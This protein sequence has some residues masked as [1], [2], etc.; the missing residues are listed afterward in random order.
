MHGAKLTT[1]STVRRHTQLGGKVP[2]KASESGFKLSLFKKSWNDKVVL[3]IWCG[4][5]P[6][7]ARFTSLLRSA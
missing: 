4:L 7:F 2:R 6:D 1:A 5:L 3:E